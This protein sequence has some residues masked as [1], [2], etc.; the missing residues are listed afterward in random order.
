MSETTEEVDLLTCDK[1]SCEEKRVKELLD[2][3]LHFDNTTPTTATEF[4]SQDGTLLIRTKAL[5]TSGR[6]LYVWLQGYLKAAYDSGWYQGR[7]KEHDACRD[8]LVRAL[9]VAERPWR[10]AVRD[11]ALL[12]QENVRL[13]NENAELKKLTVTGAMKDEY[14]RGV[15]AGVTSAA[16]TL[17]QVLEQKKLKLAQLNQEIETCE[18]HLNSLKDRTSGINGETFLLGNVLNTLEK[19]IVVLGTS[20]EE[21]P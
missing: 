4:L 14:A 21:E 7:S 15:K 6:S 16:D 11:V 19:K 13:R 17:K 20:V 1:E 10:G 12:V 18:A 9:G 3:A 8:S 5:A 2:K